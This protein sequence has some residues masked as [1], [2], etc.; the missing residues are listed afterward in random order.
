MRR[1]LIQDSFLTGI[2]VVG[3]VPLVHAGDQ[4][5]VSVSRGIVLTIAAIDP[6][7]ATATLQTPYG[8]E[9]FQTTAYASWKVGDKVECDLVGTERG[10]ALHDC[11]PWQ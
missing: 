7:T 8:E 10:Q 2:L 5:K 4:E 6:K 3:L 1:R 9:T 11:K